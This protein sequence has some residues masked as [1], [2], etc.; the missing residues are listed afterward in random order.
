MDSGQLD[1]PRGLSRFLEALLR[2]SRFDLS[3]TLMFLGVTLA[4]AVFYAKT[5]AIEDG[6]VKPSTFDQIRFPRIELHW[7]RHGTYRVLTIETNAGSFHATNNELW[8]GICSDG[9]LYRALRSSTRV[10]LWLRREDSRIFGLEAGGLV[11][12]ASVGIRHQMLV[13]RVFFWGLVIM[14]TLAAWQ[15]F[16]LYWRRSSRA[17]HARRTRPRARSH[18]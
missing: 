11:I 8:E 10:T 2:K 3:S 15:V 17:H 13:R 5:P 7:A 12:P 1:P 14:S 4:F 18:E 6:D 9:E 16:G